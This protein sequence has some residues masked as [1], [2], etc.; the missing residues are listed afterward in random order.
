MHTLTQ[1]QAHALHNVWFCLSGNEAGVGGR[2]VR[3]PL[4]YASSVTQIPGEKTETR[5][6]HTHTHAGT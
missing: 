3:L 5:P 2:L 4:P 1:T 6:R